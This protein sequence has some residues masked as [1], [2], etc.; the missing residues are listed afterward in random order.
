[1]AKA[2]G[3]DPSPTNPVEVRF[4]SEADLA[5]VIRSLDW[6]KT[7]DAEHDYGACT[8][9]P[10]T[11][12]VIDQ[13]IA[14]LAASG[15]MQG[16]IG[17]SRCPLDEPTAKKRVAAA[18]IP[19]GQLDEHL[20]RFVRL[21]CHPHEMTERQVAKLVKWRRKLEES[22]NQNALVTEEMERLQKQKPPALTTDKETDWWT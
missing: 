14:A 18:S 21:A 19:N 12:R 3:S 16:Q 1:M 17:H 2:T 10:V 20:R 8:I 7:L 15:D 6:I 5:F 13:C 22:T 11:N 4:D 9:A